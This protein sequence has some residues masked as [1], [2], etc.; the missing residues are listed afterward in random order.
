MMNAVRTS[1]AI[2]QRPTPLSVGRCSFVHLA[3]FSVCVA[4]AAATAMAGKPVPQTRPAP[5]SRPAG[6]A[7]FASGVSIDWSGRAVLVDTEVVLR[8]GPLEFFA[9]R[10][11]KEHE[12]IL[13]LNASATHIYLALG[14]IG[15]QPG[16]PPIWNETTG[17]Y[18]RAAGDLL[19][20]ECDW[21]QEGQWCH[22]AGRPSWRR[23]PKA[24]DPSTR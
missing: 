14:L 7:A 3:Q 16:H 4:A 17:D 2:N 20:V 12:S 5:D 8:R 9:C 1:I 22:A 10:P 6:V 24:R 11:G 18:E 15:L 13:R 21:Q 19:D 23:T